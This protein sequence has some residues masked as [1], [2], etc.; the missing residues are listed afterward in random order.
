MPGSSSHRPQL[1]WPL[2][3]LLIASVGF[4]AAFAACGRPPPQE[5]DAGVVVHEGP[6]DAG[7]DAGIDA[8]AT[9]PVVWGFTGSMAIA[10]HNHTAT[11]LNSGK[12]MVVGGQP[13]SPSIG[14]DSTELYSPVTGSW[15][16]AA[17]LPEPRANHT[18]SLLSDGR[19]LVA[20]GG[21]STDQGLPSGV[22]VTG[23]A[24]VYDPAANSFT[25][26][27]PMAEA[28]SFHTATVLG[29]GK[30]LV[31]GGAGAPN[32]Q[33]YLGKALSSAELWDPATG[34][35]AATGSMSAARSQHTA[36]LLA[37]G[38]VL[39]LGGANDLARSRQSAE[40][41]DPGTGAWTPGPTPPG[42]ARNFHFAELLRS[43]RVLMGA[44]IQLPDGIFLSDSALFDPA[45]PGWSSGG[46]LIYQR[47]GPFS[48][49]LQS[50]AVLVGAGGNCGQSIC[51]GSADTRI[52]DEAS[53][54]WRR[55]PELLAALWE[56]T[57]TLLRSG[58]V[59][60]TGGSGYAG[61]TA[62]CELS[63]R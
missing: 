5:A 36:T 6:D 4:G 14:I 3:G 53:G 42:P 50:G 20:G 12:V 43:G 24:L 28:R 45:V 34:A 35:W 61:V 40:I 62:Q 30:V 55:G 49:R 33:T 25:P 58:D 8:G 32:P 19:I 38:R 15:T 44:G 51:L 31:T 47:S 23:T 52:F 10:R 63:S 16:P 13:E 46:D 37:D 60:L 57:A 56:P 29:N 22:D 59:L 17:T 7:F 54:A 11:L 41:Y 9:N 21:L 18:A 27:Q 26:A 1:E 48:V 2:A 39:V